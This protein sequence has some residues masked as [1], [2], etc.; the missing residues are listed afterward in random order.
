MRFEFR[1]EDSLPRLAWCARLREGDD[2]AVL[3]HGP[4]VEA[5]GDWFVEGAWNGP[6][7][8]GRFDRAHSLVGTGGRIG[9]SGLVFCT[10]SSFAHSLFTLRLGAERLLSNSLAFLLVQA[11]DDLDPTYPH[12][13]EDL[14][15]FRRQGLRKREKT[16]RTRLGGR[17]ALHQFTDIA[18][19]RDLSVREQEK[20][21]CA[22]PRDFAEYDRLLGDTLAAVIENAGDPDPERERRYRPVAMVSRGY[23]SSA[24]T[25]LAARAGCREALTFGKPGP[26]DPEPDDGGAQIAARLGIETR[27]YSRLAFKRL[28]GVV[29]AEFYACPSGGAL[30]LAVAEEQA[31]SALL[32]SGL[33]GDAVWSKDRREHLPQMRR[34]R[35]AL[36][37]TLIDTSVPEFRMCVGFL[38]L[39]V[40]WIGARHHLKIWEI[41]TS[42]AM[43]PWSVGGGYDR[44]V[45]RRI[46]EQAGVPRE[47]FGRK[48]A[49]GLYHLI[50]RMKSRYGV[51][52]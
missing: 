3:L 15:E 1:R 50:E 48:K 12:Y 2:R 31:E 11:G 30:P 52:E 22:A 44:P 32:I 43:K 37:R 9:D 19:S 24:A 46:A 41:T 25:A 26:D 28:P 45:P 14:A 6:F 17:I 13:A 7:S 21:D 10:P 27:E 23:D 18:V 42:R 47:W 16:L 49:A 51:R 39:P 35:R 29:D 5:R 8:E 34:L 38:T 20:A 40:P 33:G 36:V 4:W